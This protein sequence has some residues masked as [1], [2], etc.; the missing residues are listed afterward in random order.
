MIP[1]DAVGDGS[2]CSGTTVIRSLNGCFGKDIETAPSLIRAQEQACPIYPHLTGVK[3]GERIVFLY[4]SNTDIYEYL[5]RLPDEERRLDATCRRLNNDKSQCN[6][7][8]YCKYVDEDS[9]CVHYS[10]ERRIDDWKE[11]WSDPSFCPIEGKDGSAAASMIE[12][13][14]SLIGPRDYCSSCKNDGD[15]AN[16]RFMCTGDDDNKKEDFCIFDDDEWEETKR[17]YP[18]YLEYETRAAPNSD[19]D[20]EE[21]EDYSLR[22]DQNNLM[23]KCKH[24]RSILPQGIQFFFGSASACRERNQKAAVYLHETADEDRMIPCP[25]MNAAAP[26]STS[27][28][29]GVDPESRAK[30]TALQTLT[31]ALARQLVMQQAQAEQRVRSRGGSGLVQ[32]RSYNGG[33]EDYFDAAVANSNGIAAIHHHANFERTMGL[34]E[35]AAVLNGVEFWT[36]HNDYLFRMNC[37]SKDRD[38]SDF[39]RPEL[40]DKVWTDFPTFVEMHEYVE[41]KIAEECSQVRT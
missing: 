24:S 33:T 21:G 23:G 9:Q 17:L 36:R 26:V 18:N 37:P 16:A 20:Y 14:I 39:G 40:K 22:L 10:I 29:I 28:A 3:P 13:Q 8:D 27:G 25:E 5:H 1:K 2:K 32:V 35:F 7:L 19:C 15:C 38:N 34:G 4:D 11:G 6:G 12:G 30:V 31:N 41:K